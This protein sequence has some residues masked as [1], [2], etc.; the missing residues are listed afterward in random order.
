MIRTARHLLELIEHSAED[1]MDARQRGRETSALQDALAARI[2]EWDRTWN[3][4]RPKKRPKD[5]DRRRLLFRLMIA[6]DDAGMPRSY[7]R[8]GPRV[9][10]LREAL[11]IAATDLHGGPDAW[12]SAADTGCLP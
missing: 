4:Q 2:A 11:R 5:W 12:K 8:D 1:I 3:W 7:H 10:L 6:F 9:R